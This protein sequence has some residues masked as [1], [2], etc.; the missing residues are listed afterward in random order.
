MRGKEI[1][2]SGGKRFVQHC[3]G[4]EEVIG[5]E[6]PEFLFKIVAALL[7]GAC[8]GIHGYFLFSRPRIE[9]VVVVQ[10]GRMIFSYALLLLAWVLLPIYL[11][12]PLADDW[13]ILIPA[14]IR[15]L[16][17]LILLGGTMGFLSAHRALGRNWSPVL[18]I[19]RRQE[20][21]ISGPYRWIRHPM[22]A[23]LFLVHMGMAFVTA[24]WLVASAFV[25]S[26]FILYFLRVSVEER[27]MV[28]YFG[29]AYRIYMQRT[30]RLFPKL[31]RKGSEGKPGLRSL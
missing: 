14:W 2:P 27:M 18:E 21:V 23:A 8:A 9:K 7:A 17:A 1:P 19:R 16:G 4:G 10:K 3:G 5:S 29:E 11:L 20:L 30:D 22:Y 25:G 31:D 28:E 15:W 6:T 26:I 12:S 24:N 13:R